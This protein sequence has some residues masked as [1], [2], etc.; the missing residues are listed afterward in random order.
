[1]KPFIERETYYILIIDDDKED[2]YFL[3][4]AITKVLPQAIVESVYDGSE[5]LEY[6]NRVVTRPDLIFLDLNM[7]KLSG[8]A[9]LKHL[10]TDVS[11]YQVPVIILTTSESEKEK[12]EILNLGANG[13]YTKPNNI[14]DLVAMIGG[15]KTN[16]FH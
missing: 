16:I 10:K 7:G 6:L 1:M 5:A 11:L 14:G 15:L 9:T 12:M 3:R 2:H 13:F 8:K 4:T